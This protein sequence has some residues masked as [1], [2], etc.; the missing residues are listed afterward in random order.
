MHVLLL[1]GAT[2]QLINVNGGA[3]P[4]GAEVQGQPTTAELVRQ[5]AASP[6]PATASHAATPAA[7]E[8]VVSS[9]GSLRPREVLVAVERG[10]LQKVA[11]WLRKGGA[12]DG[13]EYNYF[14]AD[15][16][17]ITFSLL[18]AAAANRQLEMARMLLKQG[19]SVDL[20]DSLGGTALMAAAKSQHGHPSIVLLLLQHSANPD[21]QDNY[22]YTALMLAASLGQEACVQALLRAGANTELLDE[23]Y[24]A[25]F[26]AL[27]W[28][29][30]KGHTATAKLLRQHASCLS[31]G[32][33]VALCAG[34]PLA[35]PWLVLSV[36]LGAI[37]TVAFSR[38][39]TAG[40]GQRRAAR[41]RRAQRQHRGHL[42]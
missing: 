26:T 22:G 15:G 20:R 37:A 21:V 11:K 41:Q 39:L 19:A 12:V 23:D 16:Q 4:Q 2:T 6:E 7:D 10:E 40:P 29:E 8:P 27:Q 30:A 5:H 32:L 34:L 17:I 3:V 9:P 25:R 35:W 38:T 42:A 28:A 1:V 18:H 14:D 33:G 36:V 13:L 24:G 31:L